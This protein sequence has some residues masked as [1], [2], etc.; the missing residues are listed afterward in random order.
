MKKTTLQIAKKKIERYFKKQKDKIFRKTELNKIFKENRNNWQLAKSASI[1]KF[2]KF[3]VKEIEM[4]KIELNFPNRKETRYVIGEINIYKILS[5]V[6]PNG[7]FSHL[8][9]LYINKI[10]KDEPREIYF[11]V[12]QSIKPQYETYLTQESI[13]RAFENKNR[14][15]NNFFEYHKYKIFGLSGKYAKN[16][17][18]INVDTLR[19]T[20]IERTLIDITVRPQ[21]AGG[22]QN[23][24]LA[25]ESNKEHVSMEKLVKYLNKL[26]FIYPYHQSIG[27]YLEKV[28][29]EDET[30]KLLKNLG[31]ENDFYLINQMKKP[32][33]SEKWRIY[34]PNNFDD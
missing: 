8:S 10:L 17:G 20:D 31:L 7:Y 16:L 5:A 30:L 6:N 25:Y 23:V 18:V 34:F 14:V 12:E 21:Y 11:N 3:L 19:T 15:T 28:G 22:I 4:N 9:A 32:K 29:V 1:N 26:N 2:I 27:W 24:L 33:Y 13:K